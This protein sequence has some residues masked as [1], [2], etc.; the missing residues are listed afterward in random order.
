MGLL[1]ESYLEPNSALYATL[2]LAQ[3]IIASHHCQRCHATLKAIPSRHHRPITTHPRPPNC[4]A[5]Q[6]F[7][8]INP[9]AVD[10]DCYSA[11]AVA[12]RCSCTPWSSLT[13]LL[14]ER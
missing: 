10:I 14:H 7:L 9:C 8:H 2:E 3:A 6:H 11:T 4:E 1:F 5:L 12:C 13:I